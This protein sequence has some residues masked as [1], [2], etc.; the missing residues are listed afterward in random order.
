MAMELIRFLAAAAVFLIPGICLARALALGEGWLDWFATGSSLGLASAVYLG[1]IVSHFDLRLFYPAWGV[2]TL[3]CIVGCV[4]ARATAGTSRNPS[5]IWLVLILVVVGVSRYAV[6]LPRILPPGS[7]DPTFHMILA[8]QIQLTHQAINRWPFANVPLNYPTGSHL[9]LALLSD[10]SGLPLHTVFKDFIPL[11]GVLTTA[12]IYVLARRVAANTTIAVYAAGIYGLWAWYG[13]IDYFRWGGLP[14]ELGMLLFIAMLTL[15][16]APGNPGEGRG[17]G[18]PTSATKIRRTFATALLFA[19]TILV[20]HHVMVTASVILLF[21]VLW[22][23]ARERRWPPLATAAIF[24]VVLDAFYLIPYA[25]HL[26]TFHSTAMATA[27]EPMFA[28]AT[29]P[30][31]L[32]YVL[33]GFALAG[34]ILAIAR[35]VRLDAIITIAATALVALFLLCE[36]VVPAPFHLTGGFFT[37]SRFFADLNYFLPIFAAAALSCLQTQLRAPLWIGILV[38]FIAPLVDMRR[39]QAMANL[40]D[41]PPQYL[42]ACQ[43]IQQN[44]PVDTLVDNA[45]PWTTYLCWREAALVPMPISEPTGQYHPAAQR[46]PL[47]LA[48]KIAPQPQDLTIVAMRDLHS[49]NGDPILWHDEFGDL[50]VQEWPLTTSSSSAE[51]TPAPKPPGPPPASA[52]ASP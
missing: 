16:P 48:G 28:L 47:I 23:L 33:S 34:I 21:L 10:I 42:Q 15:S 35:K 44:T 14:N 38:I 49:Y 6:A 26:T 40:W 4:R 12:Q 32:G 31:E 20:H 5:Q 17:G 11:L 19:S 2:F 1:A 45:G 52:P 43:W 9:L 41:A 39:W 51:V 36:F 24:G 22:Q 27:G 25:T 18:L 50:V 7:L 3:I 46:I 30:H 13:S 29:L 8:R 37:P